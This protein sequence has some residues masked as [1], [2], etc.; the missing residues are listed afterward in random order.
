VLPRLYA[1]LDAELT[2]SR[3]LD[4]LDLLDR[5]L[6]AGVRLVQLRA[7]T[8]PGRDLLALADAV[9][10]RARAAGATFIVNDRADVARL[11]GAD[12]V[13]LGQ[14][15]LR[16][17]DVRRFLPD[18]AIVGLSTHNDSQVQAALDEPIS[19]LAIGPVFATESKARP[20]PVVGLDGVR[21]AAALAR[22]CGVP[23][24]AIGGITADRAPLVLD[25]GATS[26]AVLGDLLDGDPAARVRAHLRLDQEQGG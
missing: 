10:K 20:D 1:I 9:A 3:G 16:P 8:M 21:R 12:G 18:D 24:V 15:D 6:E 25:A 23:V 17:A 26:L 4:P 5:W 2:A 19:Y 13:H 14:E 11:A 7:K 22:T